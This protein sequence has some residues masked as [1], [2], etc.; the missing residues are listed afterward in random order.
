VV[1]GRIYAIGGGDKRGSYTSTVWE[2][3]PAMD[4][5][6]EKADMP[7][8]RKFAP[9][10]VI[11]GKIY[12][13]G[14]HRPN[15]S[16]T[17]STVEEY[18]PVA[19]TWTK[20]ADMPAPRAWGATSVVD[21]KIYYFGGYVSKGGVPLS[22]LFQY[23]PATDTWTAKDDIPVRM[24]GLSTSVVD[25]RIYVIGGTSAGY[26]YNSGF[27]STVWEYDTGLR[28]SSPDINGDGIVDSADVSIMVDHWLMDEPLIDIAPEPFGD[29]IVDT[30]DL[31]LLREST[32]R[33]AEA[34]MNDFIWT[35][36]NID[37]RTVRLAHGELYRQTC[38]DRGNSNATVSKKHRAVKRLF[39]LAVNRK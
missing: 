33:I 28:V 4:T 30:K 26:P 22:T 2:Y 23:E 35:I 25:G 7:T 27:L 34:A 32:R 37:F 19:D 13:F 31:V 9:T 5:W 29:G 39:K 8:A 12:A 14:G 17:Y 18:D 15:A 24:A 6:T 16:P 20:K 38:L 10:G 36:G 3:D 21:G 11:N 1:N